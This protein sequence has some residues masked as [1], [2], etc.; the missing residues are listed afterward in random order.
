MIYTFRLKILPLKCMFVQGGRTFAMFSAHA[1]RE[2]LGMPVTH[3][4]ITLT[5]FIRFA[6]NGTVGRRLALC[7]PIMHVA[8]P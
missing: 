2:T 6:E 7:G 1:L 5:T 4:H 8:T 3:A